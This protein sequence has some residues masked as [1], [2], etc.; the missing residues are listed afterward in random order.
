MR[1]TLAVL[2]VLLLLVPTAAV[3]AIPDARLTVSGLTVSPDGPVTGEPVTVTATVQNAGGSPEPVEIDRVVLRMAD[4]ERLDTTQNPGSLSQGGSLTVDLVTEFDTAGRADLKVVAVGT[5]QDGDE[6]RVVRPLTVVVESA[7]P[8]TDVT[9]GEAVAGVETPVSVTVSNPA[10]TA[11]RNVK[12]VWT[13]PGD[14]TTRTAVPALAA[15]ASAIVNLS[16]TPE[17]AGSR[18]ATLAVSY[19]TSTGDR[20]TVEQRVAYDI[21][22]LREDLQ[23]SASRTPPTDGNDDGAAAGA[24]AGAGLA[25]GG[26]D[27]G[28]GTDLAAELGPAETLTVEVTNLGN[29]VA[30]GVVV[31]PVLESESAADRAL[32]HEPVG[33]LAPGE[34]AAVTVDLSDRPLGVGQ[35][36]NVTLDYRAATG[37]DRVVAGTTYPLATLR[38]DVGVAVSREPE[39]QQGANAGGQLGAVLG[40]AAAG[41]G[42]GGGGSL[43]SQEGDD[44]PREAAQV[45]VTNF[46]NV[47][48]SE[49]VVRPAVDGTELPRRSVGALAPGESGT[50]AVDLSGVEVGADAT[51]VATVGYRYA[52]GRVGTATGT[53]EYAPAAGEVRLTDVD[54]A[55]EDDGTLRITGNTGNV[56]DGEVSAAVVAVGENE[57]VSPAYPRR[58]YFIGSISASEFAPFELT[59]EIDAR[60]ATGIPVTVTYRT[61]GEE[62]TRYVTLPYDADLAPEERQRGLRLGGLGLASTGALAGLLVAAVVFLPAAYLVRR[63]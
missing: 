26:G 44:G 41:G 9:V 25:G 47:P 14:E 57:H 28:D 15:G 56:G 16:F 45:E 61:G 48:V 3:G 8:A 6:V 31:R 36:L 43:Q 20:Q 34:S 53:Y 7:R 22:P 17:A 5:D 58:T 51:L 30:E 4:D 38:Q 60:N 1:R 24:G 37:T 49:V 55:F 12:L 33:T 32:P 39:Q 63:R 2:M 50:V 21:A 29:T 19:T 54:L 23:V 13:G 40:G 10:A 35:S 46:G 11:R 62:V 18:E 27:G 52:G 42:G 59:A